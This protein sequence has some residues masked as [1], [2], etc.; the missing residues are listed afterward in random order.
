M[1]YHPSDLF[2]TVCALQSVIAR[3]FVWKHLKHISIVPLVGVYTDA[4]YPLPG[5]VSPMLD[6]GS[7]R[8]VFQL[9]CTGPSPA[10]SGLPLQQW[11][12]IA[13]AHA[14][15]DGLI[16]RIRWLRSQVRWRTCTST[17][18]STVISIL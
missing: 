17:T 14:R 10:S 8:T 6:M 15:F 1:I 2:V 12:S 11:V 18:S 3:A 13:H 5:L 7:L 16:V 9:S 4:A